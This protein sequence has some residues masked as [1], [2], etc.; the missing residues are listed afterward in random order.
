MFTATSELTGAAPL[1]VPVSGTV[2]VSVDRLLLVTCNQ[3]DSAVGW[4][5]LETT[6]W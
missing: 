6:E 3:S 1:C 4:T 2:A 5:L